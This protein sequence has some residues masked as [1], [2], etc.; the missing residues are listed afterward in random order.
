MLRQKE[1]SKVSEQLWP[2][3]QQLLQGGIE[4]HGRTFA[5]ADLELV[6][7]AQEILVLAWDVLQGLTYLGWREGGQQ[8]LLTSSRKN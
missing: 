6:D 7:D 3:V 8:G 1:G 4:I 5:R 2:V